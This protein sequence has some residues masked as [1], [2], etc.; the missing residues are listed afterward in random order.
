VAQ[1][2]AQD[3]TSGLFYDGT[4]VIPALV[5]PNA[6]PVNVA[7]WNWFQSNGTVIGTGQTANFVGP[8]GTL[9]VSPNVSNYDFSLLTGGV[10][11]TT[12]AFSGG[13]VMGPG[14]ILGTTFDDQFF[15]N[16]ADLLNGLLVNGDGGANDQITIDP[17][18]PLVLT[19]T[20]AMVQ[21]VETLNLIDTLGNTI[22]FGAG[23][24]IKNING[25]IGPDVINTLN[26]APG[27]TID[28]SNA[29]AD[30]DIVNLGANLPGTTIKTGGFT[31][32]NMNFGGALTTALLGGQNS[33]L[34]VLNNGN[35]DYDI[36]GAAI[37]NVPNLNAAQITNHTV[38]VAPGEI[39][40]TTG[41][42]NI[43]L[44]GN[45]NEVLKIGQAGTADFTNVTMS[46]D[47]Y[48]L[49][50]VANVTAK[51]HVSQ[52]PDK[53]FGT[54]TTDVQNF[55][56]ASGTVVLTKNNTYTNLGTV[57]WN[58]TLT[59]DNF[60]SNHG[61]VGLV[62]DN[63]VD[64]VVTGASINLTGV[65]T[66]TGINEVDA[67]LNSGSELKMNASQAVEVGAFANGTIETVGVLS[68]MTLSF[69]ADKGSYDLGHLKIT[70]AG[71][72]TAWQTLNL[73]SSNVNGITVTGTQTILDP[74]ITTVTG[75]TG[76]TDNLIINTNNDADLS[77]ITTFSGFKNV[78]VNDVGGTTNVLHVIDA[79]SATTHANGGA[80]TLNL[81]NNSGDTAWLDTTLASVQTTYTA[82]GK[83]TH[84]DINGFNGGSDPT[85]SILEVRDTTVGGGGGKIVSGADFILIANQTV[86][87][88]QM[89]VVSGAL[90]PVTNLLD[91]SNNGT[92]ETAIATNAGLVSDGKGVNG[93]STNHEH[94]Y[95][96]IYGA[97]P[98]ANEAG[99]YEVVF[100]ATAGHLTNGVTFA[101]HTNDFSVNLVGLVHNTAQDSL[102]PVNF[103]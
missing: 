63:S 64:L 98:S 53:I 33:E 86:N 96:T 90:A 34:L 93:G 1:F 38:T 19:I 56:D 18:G 20:S 22:S 26:M 5:F 82:T 77:N 15:V 68:G 45:V 25:S 94:I 60:N 52:L 83:D 84:W 3:G 50:E 35:V 101:G 55:V 62:G 69:V 47:D 44:S 49:S 73:D 74:N 32:V 88:T 95:V 37:T 102:Q 75:G 10:G 61:I 78:T 100:D 67:F 97:G 9:T 41:F 27:G 6:N 12:P 70:D 2:N 66:F 39:G 4:K 46:T 28:L 85:H 72:F 99:I 40:G 36:S 7:E 29:V 14:T 81:N 8:G 13:T 23:T 43:K 31:T 51:M 59:I 87:H 91:L 17:P 30:L 54:G 57:Q 89:N 92:V 16:N 48:T 103:H 42:T 24:G 80:A 11:V 58:D 71:L 79:I 21:N 76:N 65:T